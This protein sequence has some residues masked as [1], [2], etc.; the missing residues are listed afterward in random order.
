MCVGMQEWWWLCDLQG[1]RFTAVDPSLEPSEFW[2]IASR[3]IESGNSQ[4]EPVRPPWQTDED[5]CPEMDV[6]D[7]VRGFLM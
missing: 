4:G 6:Q 7:A 1:W 2:G 3:S 5:S